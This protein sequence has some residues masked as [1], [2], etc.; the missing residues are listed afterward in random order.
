[1]RRRDSPAQTTEALQKLVSNLSAATLRIG[2][3]LDLDTVLRETAE[4]ARAL[5][6]ARFGAVA[7]ADESGRPLEF[8]TSG[9]TNEERREPAHWPGGPTLFAYVRD[10]P[11]PLRLSDGSTLARA[12]HLTENGPP[13]GTFLGMPMHRGGTHIGNIYLVDKEE[14]R[15]F[16]R[17][18][19]R[20]LA[21]LLPQAAAAIANARTHWAERRARVHLQDLVD[22]SPVG[23]AVFDA[24]TGAPVSVNR[25]AGRIVGSLSAP[26]QPPESSLRTLTLRRADGRETPLADFARAHKRGNGETVQGEKAVLLGPG[27]RCQT[28]VLNAKA[29][30]F[31][32]D[33]AASVV[34][35]M[36]E[37]APP[38]DPECRRARFLAMVSH[39]L[40]APLISI[41]GAAATLLD[42]SSRLDPAEMREYVRIVAEQADHMGGLISDL[43][44]SW[45]IDAGTLAVWPEP[46]QVATLVERAR[47]TF[48]SG[49][50]RHKL[51]VD[52]A[53]GLPPV[54]ADRQRIVQVLNNLLANAARHSSQSDPI[55]IAATQEGSQVALSVSD[56]GRGIPPERLA[57][58]FSKYAAGHTDKEE[59][60]VGSGL[61]LS[62][63]RGLVEA[64]G[65]RILAE[66]GGPGQGARFT[67]TLPA[68]DHG[69]GDGPATERTAPSR[70]AGE[71]ARI[72]VVDDDPQTLR[73]LR[74]ALADAGYDP[75][76]T[77][78]HRE[79]PRILDTEKPELVLLDLML[80]GAD[81]I[82]LMQTVSGLAD[83]P[84]IFLS[85]Y[86]RDETI[87]KAFEAGAVDYVV[88]P[89]SPTELVARIG[90]TLRRRSDPAPFVLGD[91]AID[92]DRRGVS[93][94]G[95]P[96]KLTPTEY[97]LLHVLAVNAGRVTTYE[98]LLRQ[99][100]KGRN[101]GTPKLVRAFVKKLRHKLGEDPRQPA[102]IFT[103]HGM[104]YRM[105]VP[106][107]PRVA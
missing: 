23:I 57:D 102:Y 74:G 98:T 22:A 20:V 30:R 46:T 36:K 14:G 26:G 33:A 65:G 96:V 44:D 92:Y 78:D 75:L 16:A 34:L 107:E 103:V 53:P 28:T 62:I 73:D 19:E 3:S 11:Q 85:C 80:P 106:D 56:E 67:F 71:R 42:P 40:R 87:A 69:A 25:E 29:I 84:V 8:V 1:M 95:R 9:P 105:P 4:G 37:L 45:R 21:L 31:A 55:R 77:G 12:L 13:S 70:E 63:C 60:G 86:G 41:K 91:L 10:L 97:E 43:H 18:D 68:A 81:G 5:T 100:W 82:A 39:E 101:Y 59:R 79:L 7:T 66:S 32:D 48:L 61:G 35:A 51:L 99:V 90:A 58:L 15:N 49:P 6:G 88:K 27:G 104:G 52:L 72:L 64:H 38:E 83:L 17:E 24:R 47:N 76:V 2:A 93:M 50:A 94:A 89:F 54:I